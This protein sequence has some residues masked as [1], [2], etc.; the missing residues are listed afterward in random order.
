MCSRNVQRESVSKT[1][2]NQWPTS[3]WKSCYLHCISLSYSYWSKR[4]Q[5][6]IS[7]TW[8]ISPFSY[9]DYT[10]STQIIILSKNLK[11]KINKTVTLPLVLY[12]C[13]TWPLTLRDGHSTYLLT[14]L[15]TY[16]LTYLLTY[17]L[18]YSMVK[19]KV[20]PVLLTKHHAMKAYWGTYLLTYLLHGAGYYL[21]S[22]LSFIL[23]KIPRFL[24]EP[25]GSS[26]C[27]QKP[28]TGPYPKPAES[29]SPHRCLSL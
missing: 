16:I 17:L 12:R 13:Q 19:G 6:N 5:H 10:I 28:A 18:T 20:V 7:P 8:L 1:C 29:S 2:R 9:C 4:I 27:S 26:P 14:Y 15:L 21:K 22:W 3:K 24:M 25:E 11:S 23:S